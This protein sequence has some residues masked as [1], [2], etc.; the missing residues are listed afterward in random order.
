[1]NDSPADCLHR[2]LLQ[3]LLHES[4][5]VATFAAAHGLSQDA[6]CGHIEALRQSGIEIIATGTGEYTL[7]QPLELLDAKAVRGQLSAKAQA[8]LESLH[9]VW[10]TASTNDVLLAQPVPARGSRVL[11]AEQQTAGRGRR[12]RHW[13]SPLA[14]NLYLSLD[15]RF[16]GGLARLSGLSLV[17]GIAVAEAL[18][19]HTGLDVRLKWPNDLWLAGRKLGGLLVEGGSEPGGAAR[20]VIGLGL[21]V[22]MPP[23]FAQHI[24]QAWVD[25]AGALGQ[26]PSRNALL[27]AL[28][29]HVLPALEAFDAQ[30]LPPFLSRWQALDALAGHHVQVKAATGDFHARVLGLAENGGL[31]VLAANGEQVLYSGEVSVRAS[32]A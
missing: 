16:T 27:A 7:A 12:G 30:G 9:V 21:N 31:R 11:L 3:A 4:V 23:V 15:R 14:A 17:A 8:G 24:D 32:D 20:A 29:E 6:L 13:A 22:R 10:Q 28:L 19:Q 2:V 18:R 5:H 1:M 26:L 25:L